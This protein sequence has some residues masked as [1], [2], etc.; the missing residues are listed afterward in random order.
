MD[1]SSWPWRPSPGVN[2]VNRANA[3]PKPG[4]RPAQGPGPA[5]AWKYGSNLAH[6][7]KISK[8]L[9]FVGFFRPTQKKCWDGPKWGRE[10]LFP[11][12]KNL[13]DILGRTDFDFE[14]F[15]FWVFL[16]ARFPDFQVPR[17][18]AW[19][20]LGWAGLGLGQAGWALGRVG[21]KTVALSKLVESA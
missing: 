18:L 20:G 8:I 4:P 19:A 6:Q 12:N 16:V 3:H 2:K 5:Q 9:G 1:T 17:N 13:A 21:L 14:N 11:A 7:G 15:Y 10:V